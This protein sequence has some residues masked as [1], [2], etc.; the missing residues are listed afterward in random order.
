MVARL[1]EFSRR[2]AAAV[3]G[4]LLLL[5]LGAGLYAAGHLTVDSDIQHLL[6]SDP[7]WRQREIELDRD[8][9][10]NANLL[11]VVIDGVTPDLADSAARRLAERMR[12]APQLFRDVRQ[13]D[14]GPFFERYGLLF[15]PG[16]DLASMSQ[17]LVEA[18]PLLGS[19]AHDP[20]L[21]GLFEALTLFLQGVQQGHGSVELLNPTLA[22]VG[23]AVQTVL[24]GKPEPVAWQQVMTGSAPDRRELRRFILTRPVLDFGSL[25]PGAAAT[26]EIRRLAQ[27]LGLGRDG[28]VRV[29]ITGPIAL[30]DEQF[31]TLEAGAVRSLVVSVVLVGAILFAAL[32]S[33]RLAG[34]ILVTLAAGLALSAG[35]AAVAIGSLNLISIAFA[36]L[37]IGLAVDFSIQFSIRYR[38]ERHRQGEF[39]PALGAAA[40]SIGPALTLAA[41]A[42][43]IGFLSFVPTPYTGVRELGWI[44]GAGMLIAIMLNF[45]M[46]PA[47]LTLLR[48]AGEPAPVGFRR[49][50]VIDRFL[51]A[52]RRWV[53]LAAAALAVAS[54]AVLP[55]V[56]FD[57]DPLHL[58][59]TENESVSTALDLMDD[60]TTSPYAAEVLVPSLAEAQR[61]AERLGGLPEVADVV[62]AA[63][64]IPADQEKKLAI[65]GDLALLLGPTLAPVAPLPAPTEDEVLA[66]LRHC[67]EALQPIVASA[68]PQS[69][70]A[71]LHAALGD[72]I[73]R[74]APAIPALRQS[75]LPGLLHRIEG[76]RELIQAGPITLETLPAE[77]RDGW[78]APDG[79]ARIEVFPKGDARDN[80]VLQRFVA[81]IRTVAPDATG[82]PVTIQE[83]GLLIG[84]SFVE[85]GIIAVV[86]ITVLLIIVLRR[87]REVAVVIAPLLLA[88]LLTLAMTVALGMPLNYANI[89]ALPLLLGIGVAFDI[90]FVMNWRAGVTDHLQS[91]TARAVLFSALTTMSAFGSLAL[92][93]D[94]GTAGMGKLLSLSLA[95][96]LFCTL[97]V[98]PAL[99][100]PATARR[101]AAE[102]AAVTAPP[103]LKQKA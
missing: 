68:G 62:T 77:L 51:L 31:A 10:Q 39:V 52:R 2:R 64:Y 47:G 15:L 8:F 53:L 40:R 5:S 72:A 79:K 19:L 28:G 88:A 16:D 9:P 94:P 86:A 74:G 12:A 43:A 36:V 83:A 89:I 73:A 3:A 22:A 75:L 4:F 55:W 18:Q 92:S 42:T 67:R 71:R 58:K 87:L 60:P 20:S 56:R 54:L 102:A 76:L 37:F 33:V 11:A 34:A 93:E 6:P 45:L 35:F 95:C 1:V 49:A 90:Y 26:A 48:P 98:L 21:R 65:V 69:P 23:S 70:A 96:T 80:A 44:A 32:R 30:D 100:G 29:R 57:F 103:R 61:L 81:A 38:D 7:A 97:F 85:A 78:I 25:E 59:S 99:L 82:T 13:P 101:Q 14:G 41:A 46:L 50:A 17:R 63:T 66:A 84:G 91:S 27:E 24:D